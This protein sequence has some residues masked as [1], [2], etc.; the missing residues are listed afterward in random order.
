VFQTQAWVRFVSESQKVRPV[1]AELRDGAEVMGYFTGLTFAKF[2]VRVLGSSFPGWTTPYMGFNLVQGASRADALRA[3]ETVAW[4]DLKCMHIEVSD[5]HLT[6]EDGLNLG[7][8]GDSYSSY[9]TD[10]T[11]SRSS[12]IS[13]LNSNPLPL[14]SSVRHRCWPACLPL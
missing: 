2:G 9:R 8:T 14:H 10:L 13:F 6:L 12:S 5:P 11:R 7:F 4:E 1:L 3:L